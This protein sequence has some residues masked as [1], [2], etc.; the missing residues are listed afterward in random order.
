MAG[1]ATGGKA[2]A[3]EVDRP[4]VGID[5]AH[6]H[7]QR[8]GLAGSVRS[9]DADALSRR[10]LEVHAVD[11]LGLAESLAQPRGMQH[12]RASGRVHSESLVGATGRCRRDSNQVRDRDRRP[13]FDSMLSTMSESPH[14]AFVAALVAVAPHPDRAERLHLFGQFV[15]SWDLTVTDHRPGRETSGTPGEWHFGWLL[16]GNAVGDVWIYPARS[17]GLDQGRARGIGALPRSRW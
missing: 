16:G 10:D 6:D 13:T 9:D 1:T 7:Q 8:R 4:F 2:L 5:R 14:E 17:T 11:G 12:R 15:G 3:D